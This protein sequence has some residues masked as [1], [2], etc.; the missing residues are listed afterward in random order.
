MIK[1][2]PKDLTKNTHFN[3]PR[4]CANCKHSIATSVNSDKPTL[5]CTLFYRIELEY[6]QKYYENAINMRTDENKCGLK[7]QYY[8]GRTAGDKLV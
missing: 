2:S 4:L 8:E 5:K 6:G 7:A 1:I 3:P